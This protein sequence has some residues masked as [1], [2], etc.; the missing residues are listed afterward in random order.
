MSC[1]SPAD[2][3]ALFFAAVNSELARQIS[4]I[5]SPRR[6]TPT[7]TINI[8]RDCGAAPTAGSYIEVESDRP[9]QIQVARSACKCLFYDYNGKLAP[10]GKETITVTVDGARAKMGTLQEQLDVTAKKDPSVRA[11]FAVQATIR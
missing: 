1:R 11:S 3:T 2:V 7:T 4:H 8:N 6:T 5:S 9:V 10:K